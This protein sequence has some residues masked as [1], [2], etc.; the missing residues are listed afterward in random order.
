MKYSIRG[1]VAIVEKDD[2]ISLVNNYKLWK[3]N[4][5]D[6]T[7]NDMI[8]FEVWLDQK[9]NKD[10]LFNDLKTYVNNEDEYI[11]WHYCTHDEEIPQ[12]CIIEEVYTK[13][14]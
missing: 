4:M 8:I 1:F 6:D 13:G 2:V 11:D 10:N 7:E 14:E 3:L 9:S 5:Q 12:P